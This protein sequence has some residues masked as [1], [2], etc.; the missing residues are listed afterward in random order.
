MGRSRSRSRS[1][2]RGRS[3]GG[4]GGGGAD[5]SRIQKLVD[6]RSECRRNREFDRADKLRDELRDLDVNVDDTDGS[7]RGP[8]GTAGR[9]TGGGGGGGGGIVRRD[10]DWDCA[11]CGKMNFA[12][13]DSCFTCH[14]S[15]FA[16]KAYERSRG[17]GDSRSRGDRKRR[18]RR[19]DSRSDSRSKSRDRRRRRR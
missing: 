1:R 6:E 15:K 14:S 8:G 10:G 13:R 4:G 3:G 11:K 2:S 18:S 12:S 7:W 17:R 16:G 5:E 9:V 19:D